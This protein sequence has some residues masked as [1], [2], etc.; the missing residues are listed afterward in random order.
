MESA[1][2]TG[3]LA[4]CAVLA[5][6]LAAPSL[7]TGQ[8]TTSGTKNF[9]YD[10][11]VIGDQP[12]F[13]KVG[14]QQQYPGNSEYIN[15]IN[16]INSLR[17]KLEFSV[18]IGD[19]KAGD[20]FCS[21]DVYANNLA[22]FGRFYSPVVYLPGDNEWTDC[23]RA[24]NGAMDP[25]ERL[26]YLRGIFYTSNQ[27]LGQRT[28]PLTRQSSDPG[29]E[30]YKEN[31]MWQYGVVLFIGI[32]Q[33]GSNNNHGRTT[34]G[35]V[36]GTEAEYAARNAANIAWIRKGFSIANADP[37]TKAVVVLSQANPFERYLEVATPAYPDSGYADFIKELRLQTALL[38]RPVVYVGGDTHT[39][40]TDK[41]LG[42]QYPAPGK[43]A[44]DQKTDKRFEKFTRVEVFGETDTHWVKIHIDPNDPNIFTVS[45]QIVE[46]NVKTHIPCSATVTTGCFN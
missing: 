31:V 12:Y 22:L 7:L 37:T 40:R 15:V 10:F 33:P 43:A 46:E 2:R 28:M 30:L 11:A 39:P 29:F 6:S 32:N 38:N 36:A 17:H 3:R 14:T 44:F 18:H 25:I 9:P 34:G 5:I 8:V 42:E 41:P 23:H 1:R 13:P 35:F 24:N 4:S 21:N 27:S 20:T 45:Q 26:N 16:D 19:I